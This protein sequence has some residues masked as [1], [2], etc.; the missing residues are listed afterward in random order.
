[1][2]LRHDFDQM[3]RVLGNLLSN[4]LKFTPAGGS[5]DFTMDVDADRVLV[6]VAD[7]GPG[8][9][10]KWRERSAVVQRRR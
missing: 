1:M 2:R 7:T 6:A 8:V 4:A 5:I 3:S 10:E 9:P